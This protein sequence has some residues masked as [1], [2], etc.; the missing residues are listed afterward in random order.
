MELTKRVA[1][2]ALVAAGVAGSTAGVA[3]AAERAGGGVWYQGM[4]NKDVYSN[5]DH[6]TRC[7]SST[8]VGVRTVR[9]GDTPTGERSYAETQKSATDNQAYCRNSC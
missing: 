2:A 3:S 1:V 5:Y 4:T 6:E 9:S 8:A 7:H